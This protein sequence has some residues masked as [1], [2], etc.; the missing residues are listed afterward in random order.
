MES[1][2][3]DKVLYTLLSQQGIDVFSCL[4]GK[5]L[6]IIQPHLMP[7]GINT[8]FFWLLPYYTGKHENRNVSLYA[9]SRDYH[10]FA[11]NLA[12]HLHSHLKSAFPGEQFFFF[13]D[14]SPINEVKAALD[15]GLGVMGKNRLIINRKYGSYVFVGSMLTSAKI[16]VSQAA[17]DYTGSKRECLNC[18][19]C[20]E[21]CAFLRGENDVCLSSLNQ[22]KQVTDGQLQLIK[23]QKIRW[24][25]DVCQEVCPMNEDVSVTPIEFF[26]EDTTE[27]VTAE[28]IN[29][30]SKEQFR[31]RAYS[32]RGKNVILRNI[33]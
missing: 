7:D 4:D 26:H 13:C 12:Q 15:C 11:K 8:A 29:S 32:W 1:T 21:S 19:L 28:Y 16:D 20:K 6:Q 31:Q 25:C 10:V 24:G 30:L 33:D 18:G 22:T 5:N 17:R 9:V 27:V 23:Q 2:T 3:L 14:S